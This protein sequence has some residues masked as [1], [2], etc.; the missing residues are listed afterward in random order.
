MR[1]IIFL[2][3]F[4][5]F[6]Q[7]TFSPTVIHTY[8]F[9]ETPSG[10]R[11]MVI[12]GVVITDTFNFEDPD[13][14]YSNPDSVTLPNWSDRI[15]TDTTKWLIQHGVYRTGYKWS[16]T[17]SADAQMMVA[18]AIHN[19]PFV[20]LGFGDSNMNGTA[21][22]ITTNIPG[23]HYFWD[24]SAWTLVTT[25]SVGNS[26]PTLG[27]IYQPFASL[28]R[29]SFDRPIYTINCAKGGSYLSPPGT[30]GVIPGTG[31]PANAVAA[32]SWGTGGDL[33]G[34]AETKVAN[35]LAAIQ[36]T[37]PDLILVNATINDNRHEYPIATVETA[38]DG[39]VSWI[40]ATWPGVPVLVI[41]VGRSEFAILNQN[42]H[43]QRIK[44]INLCNAN[45]Y[46]SMVG[47]SLSLQYTG[48]MEADDLHYN[49][50]GEIYL[51]NCFNKWVRNHTLTKWGRSIVST[52]YAELTSA[53]K[54]LVDNWA[55][56]L[57]SSG[58]Y[59]EL[60]GYFRFQ[61]S[62]IN[63]IF[64]D[65]TFVNYGANSGSTYVADSHESFDGTN[66]YFAS[67]IRPDWDTRSGLND[68]FITA[69]IKDNR[70]T[71]TTS[72]FGSITASGALSFVQ[73]PIRGRVNDLTLTGFTSAETFFADDARYSFRRTSSTAKLLYKDATTRFTGSVTST[74]Q[75]TFTP[76]VASQ[77]STGPV[78][79]AY[80]DSD[81]IDFGFGGSGV[82]LTNWVT[83]TE[84]L[85]DG[86]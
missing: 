65:W 70:S 42:L 14:A 27:S 48:G 71:G 59:F 31:T 61:R 82:D 5:W 66:D 45:T 54:T 11:F 15:A 64:V 58:D 35:G 62:H 76:T 46:F 36:V 68:V 23:E 20:V 1:K 84:T 72:L 86:W 17:T 78:I 56:T 50:T 10:D 21:G 41:Q 49:A 16:L 28:H 57:V 38:M 13:S 26:T 8:S 29:A 9:H 33:R 22:T 51:A 80:L 32:N 12:D 60:T 6:F 69:K 77:Q 43:R 79:G 81:L 3:P 19:K 73:N 75:P 85:E 55:S 74:A 18:P 7:P 67:G 53:R 63:D 34:L 37:A 39:F 40:N 25:Q 4:L 30:V 2:I 47:S 52:L 83:A 24:G 44:W